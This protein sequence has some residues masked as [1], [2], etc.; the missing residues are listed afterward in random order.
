M[1]L[2]IGLIIGIV[3]CVLVILAAG[4][5][6]F[7]TDVLDLFQNTPPPALPTTSLPTMAAA[8]PNP[9]ATPQPALTVRPG[10]AVSTTLSTTLAASNSTAVSTTTATAPVPSPTADVQFEVISVE[11]SGFTR[12]VTGKLTNSGSLDLHNPKLK[13]EMYSNGKLIKNDSAAYID[14]SFPTLIA[15][16]SASDQVSIKI[17]LIDGVYVTQHGV[18]F[19][20]TFTSDELTRQFSYDYQP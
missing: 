4:V 6:Y 17:G 12:T 18:S 9:A 19:V 15:G 7:L 2:K 20:L 1:K 11:G 13:I 14:K 10:L 5:L 8:S 16:E 3:L